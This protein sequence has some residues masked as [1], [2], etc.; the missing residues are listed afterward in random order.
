MERPQKIGRREW[1]RRVAGVVAASAAAS[2]GLPASGEDDA[3]AHTAG[4][5]VTGT[6]PRVEPA[7]KGR[8]SVSR[9]A[10]RRRVEC[11][12][13]DH[14]M[15]CGYGIDIP[16]NFAYY[17]RMLDRGLV[18]DP[19]HEDETSA[20]FRSKALAYLRGYDR[21]IADSHQS[22]RCVKCFHCV[23]ECPHGVFIVNELAALTRLADRLR[24]WECRYL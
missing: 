17:N 18:P 8:K 6:S 5:A 15:P 12:E 7:A 22:Q 4:I 14:C 1:L 9:V 23:S 20:E 10:E 24:D 2:V 3:A 13:C 11:V 16:G 19:D 21:A